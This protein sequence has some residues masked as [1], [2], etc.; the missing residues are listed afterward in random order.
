MMWAFPNIH[1]CTINIYSRLHA[2]VQEML[3]LR[4]ERLQAVDLLNRL[5]TLRGRAGEIDG[6]NVWERPGKIWHHCA[7]LRCWQDFGRGHCS[8]ARA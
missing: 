5:M 4:K 2:L 3:M 1:Q 7:A 8:L 6:Q